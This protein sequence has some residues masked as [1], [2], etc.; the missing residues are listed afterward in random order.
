M[1]CPVCG[2][3]QV[4]ILGEISSYGG[5]ACCCTICDTIFPSVFPLPKEVE[6]F[7]QGFQFNSSER[8]PFLYGLFLK[9]AVNARVKRIKKIVGKHTVSRELLDFGGGCGTFTAAFSRCGYKADLYEIDEV[10]V[11]IAV[12]HKVHIAENN[13]KYGIVFSSHVIEHFI[14]LHLFFKQVSERLESGG[15]LLLSCPNKN[16]N[17]PWRK[18]HLESYFAVLKNG[19]KRYFRMYPWF[20]FDPPR[21]FY[22]ISKKTLQCLATFHQ[23]EVLEMFTEYA[24]QGVFYFNNMYTLWGFGTLIKHPVSYLH[25]IYVNIM[26]LISR[27]RGK[28]EGDNLVAILKKKSD[29]CASDG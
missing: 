4:V 15:I 3:N 24:N 29:A 27:L 1:K 28:D 9:F 23:Y 12:N 20:C 7:Y 10:A 26:S 11:K 25:R 2:A 16:A 6:N 18:K 19:D 17:E 13:K 21:H 22:A 5:N 8:A 14:D